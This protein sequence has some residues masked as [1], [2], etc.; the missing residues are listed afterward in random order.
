ML[1][2]SPLG[3][4]HTLISLVAVAA[5]IAAFVRYREISLRTVLGKVYVIT[6]V[7]TCLTGFGI[8]RNGTFGP[9]H[10]LGIITLAV[11][12]GAIALE[13]YRLLGRA[14]RY[15]ETVAYSAT[16]FFHV[17]PGFTETATRVPPSAPLATG[18]EDPG[19][20]A[21]IGV[22]FA[23]FL[24]GAVLQVWRLRGRAEDRAAIAPGA[25]AP[26]APARGE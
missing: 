19:L 15:V 18:P 7:L 13:R 22:A 21:A 1:G 23:V 5:G 6:T 10:M 20:Q 17:I 2:L 9:P 8:F 12:A 26:I 4:V 25:P 3:A 16:F 11:L 24:A 14:S